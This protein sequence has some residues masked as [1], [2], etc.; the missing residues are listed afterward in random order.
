VQNQND[1]N[2]DVD[3]A[4]IWN[5]LRRFRWL[6]LSA[7]FLCAVLAFGLAMLITPIFRAEAVITPVRSGVMGGAGGLGGQLGGLANIANLAGVN[8]DSGNSSDREAKAILQS[9]SLV[10]EFITKNHLLGELF[11]DSK[12]PPSMWLAVKNFREGVL[13]IHE[14]KRAGL[15]TIAIDWKSAAVAAQWAN[16]FIALANERIRSRAIDEAT[17]NIDFLNR[18]I[19]KT[20]V[21]EVQHALYNLIENETKTLMLANVK[22]EYAFTVIDPA[23]PPDRKT[24]PRRSLYALLGAFL[25]FFIGVLIA[26]KRSLRAKS[27]E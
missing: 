27:A 5:F 11:L 25:G 22:V 8:L 24:S 16:D 20:S 21:V 26:Y 14:D 6:I 15:L 10:A 2:G 13:A 19:A 3:F 17:R 18:Q 23:V 12:K 9:R 4:A 1:Q 7:T